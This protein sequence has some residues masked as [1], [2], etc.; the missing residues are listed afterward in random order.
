MLL[1]CGV[2][3]DSGESLEPANSKGNQCWI[4]TEST[5]DEAENPILWP[6]DEKNWLIGKDSDAGKYWGQEEKR[7]TDNEIVGWHHHF[8]GHEFE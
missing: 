1:N 6:P 4:F 3:E 7:M 2:G 8:N 5:D